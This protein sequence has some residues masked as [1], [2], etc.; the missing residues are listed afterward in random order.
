MNFVIIYWN[1]QEKLSNGVY[2]KNG[3]KWE[4]LKTSKDK[5]CHIKT[6]TVI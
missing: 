3:Y 6:L 4:E 5:H 2:N 1:P